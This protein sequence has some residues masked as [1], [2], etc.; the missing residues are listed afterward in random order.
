MKN[1]PATFQL[2][3]S[4]ETQ[5]RWEKKKSAV[6]NYNKMFFSVIQLQLNN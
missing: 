4:P 2:V 5:P 6:L 3:H 1:N